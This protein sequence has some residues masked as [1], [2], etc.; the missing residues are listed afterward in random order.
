MK[1]AQE[2][3]AYRVGFSGWDQLLPMGDGIS[4]LSGYGRYARHLA[5]G[6]GLLESAR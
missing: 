3:A 4:G 2:E 5:R 6:P 1:I